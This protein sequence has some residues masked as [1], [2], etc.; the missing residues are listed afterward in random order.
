MKYTGR[1]Q[2]DLN[3]QGY[4]RQ[5]PEGALEVREHDVRLGDHAAVKL[6]RGQHAARDFGLVPSLLLA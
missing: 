3:V 5:R 6:D 1:C 4:T 2:N